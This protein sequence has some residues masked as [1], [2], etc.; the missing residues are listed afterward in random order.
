MVVTQ[1]PQCE[2]AIL[3]SISLKISHNLEKLMALF[4]AGG[5]F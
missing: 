1:V 4:I 5:L 3:K 2:F